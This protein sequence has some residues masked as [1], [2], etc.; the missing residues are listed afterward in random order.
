MPSDTGLSRRKILTLPQEDGE[1]LSQLGFPEAMTF[2]YSR[3][4]RH[5]FDKEQME[6]YLTRTEL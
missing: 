2:D 3:I 5:R 6:G 1:M 4:N